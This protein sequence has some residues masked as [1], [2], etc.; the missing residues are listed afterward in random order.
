MRSAFWPHLIPACTITAML[1]AFSGLAGCAGG[2]MATVT[3]DVGHP[4][5]AKAHTPS[6]FDRML[7]FLSF[8][9]R[10]EAEPPPV[11]FSVDYLSITVSAPDFETITRDIPLDTGQLTLEVPAGNN[12]TFTLVAF[13]DHGDGYITRDY[14]GIVTT[15]L[16]GGATITLPI[17]MGSLPPQV[18]WP[19][20]LNAGTFGVSVDWNES[21]GAEGYYVYRS[22]MVDGPYELIVH[23]PGFSNTDYLDEDV[24]IDGEH[25]YYYKVCGYNGNGI[26][27]L[28]DYAWANPGP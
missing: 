12:R 8:S 11:D 26:G 18:T 16:Q 19:G 5:F 2:E 21:A 9:T 7:A 15:N 6:V 4:G 10:V 13:N 3:I 27:T 20:M 14:G 24:N 28:S 22:E 25:T 1:V 17:T 23:V